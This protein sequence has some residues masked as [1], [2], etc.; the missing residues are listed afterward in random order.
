MDRAACQLGE[1]K[2]AGNDAAMTFSGYGAVYGNID[3]Y[4]DMIKSGAMAPS[5]AEMHRTGIWPAMLLQHGGFGMDAESMTP[6][7]VWTALAEDGH[8]LK[9]EGKLADTPRGREVY[10]LLKME[11]RPAI[12]GLSIGY[13]A[14][15]FS[16]R[17]K[18]E[19]PRRT[20]EEIKLFEV[21]LVTFPANDKARVTA[22]K[23]ARDATIRELE[24]GLTGRGPM[25]RFSLAEA[26]AL[27]ASG[28]KTLSAAR[29]AGDEVEELAEA[30]RRMTALFKR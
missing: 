8:G 30:L 16:S 22:V 2:L 1:L 11:P 25:P 29:D 10:Q 14:V 13:S 7:G 9:V 5:L 6:I 19:D 20:L 17:A 4:G 24:A 3:S 27:L 28:F 23:S 21:S 15:K 12:T 26:K 18:P